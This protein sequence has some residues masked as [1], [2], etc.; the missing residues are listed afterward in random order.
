MACPALEAHA[1]TVKV[2]F[3]VVT[4]MIRFV[5]TRLA[6]FSK[7]EFGALFQD[8]IPVNTAVCTRESFKALASFIP[9][10]APSIATRRIHVTSHIHITSLFNFHGIHFIAAVVT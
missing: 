9:S 6:A 2:A 3:A 4:A 5:A 10:T 8:V 7:T 1:A